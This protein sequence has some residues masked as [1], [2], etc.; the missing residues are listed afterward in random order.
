MLLAADNSSDSNEKGQAVPWDSM[1]EFDGH[2]FV[3]L[4]LATAEMKT[5]D[6]QNVDDSV[7]GDPNG[8]AGVIVTAPYAK[9]KVKVTAL[10]GPFWQGGA[11]E[12]VLPRA[13]EKYWI[14]PRLRYRYDALK[15]V[16][17]RQPCEVALALEIDGTA[18]GEKTVSG[19]V[20]P[21]KDCVF[22]TRISAGFSDKV[23]GYVYSQFGWLFAAY[24][25][26][27][28]AFAAELVKEALA[29]GV[30]RVFDGYQSGDPDQVLAQV[31]ALWEAL[32]KRGARYHHYMR[33]TGA[34][35]DVFSEPVRT[36][37]EIAARPSG[38]SAEA[39]V[40][41]A[42][43]L[44]RIGLRASIVIVSERIQLGMDRSDGGRNYV[45][46]DPIYMGMEQPPDSRW[47]AQLRDSLPG[48][49]K[50]SPSL[51]A[52][53]AALADGT[54]DVVSYAKRF[55]DGDPRLQMFDVRQARVDGVVPFRKVKAGGV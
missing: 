32:T 29:T 27:E 42:S 18:L 37:D 9:A 49:F 19:T 55:E 13:G 7:F 41:L 10:A 12:C 53:G 39:V 38:T 47:P 28:H 14:A 54:D 20:H 4:L 2:L 21:V 6:G 51:A 30:V 22:G 34:S 36:L 45:G 25:D 23:L 15:A 31:F 50:D 35:K 24:V 26:E 44:L 46:I 11:T 33:V 40:L 3:S 17:A 43:A 52:F 5:I 1:L 8:L 48:P 16:K